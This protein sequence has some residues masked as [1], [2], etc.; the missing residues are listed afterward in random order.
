MKSINQVISISR[1]AQVRT[2]ITR[3][4]SSCQTKDQNCSFEYFHLSRYFM[5]S[6][7]YKYFPSGSVFSLVLLLAYL[8]YLLYVDVILL[9]QQRESIT[10]EY[11]N[12][13]IFWRHTNKFKKHVKW[14]Q[15]K[16]YM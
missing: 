6:H 2:I 7:W 15:Q 3:K 10:L 16:S 1:I 9:F 13:N 11:A 8:I 12:A 14:G 5:L 4:E